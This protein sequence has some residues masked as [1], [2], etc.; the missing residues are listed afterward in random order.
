MFVERAR[1][2][3]P[4]FTLTP[5]N[6]R[7]VAEICTRLDGI[8]LAIELAAMRMGVL[9]APQIAERLGDSLE[10]LTEG[11]RMAP[12]RHRTLTG[13]LDWSHELLSDPERAH[14]RR[15]S[16][17][18]GGWTLKAAEAVGVESGAE[19][20]VMGGDV[21]GL[22]SRLVDRSLVVAWERGGQVRY[23]LLEPLWQYGWRK[24]SESGEV[25]AVRRR[26]ATFFLALAERA[27]PEINGSRR[28]AWRTCL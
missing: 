19:S 22:M 6:V 26:H 4:G 27:K 21:L 10:L 1:S 16:V 18:A 12:P 20:S 24:L 28:E 9:S 8:P 2:R 13:T 7:A 14:F 25:V 15:L 3:R 23:R 11:G 5:E 17:F